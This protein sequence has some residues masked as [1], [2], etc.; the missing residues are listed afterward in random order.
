MRFYQAKK[1]DTARS[2]PCAGEAWGIF[3]PEALEASRAWLGE[4]LGKHYESFQAEDDAGN[5]VGEILWAWSE[6][7][8]GQ[9]RTEPKVAIISCVWVK[10]ASRRRGI[11]RGMLGALAEKLRDQGAKGILVLA[12]DYEGYMHR[13]HFQKSGFKILGDHDGT[14]VMFYPLSQE[15]VEYWFTEERVPRGPGDKLTVHMFMN[16]LCPIAPELFARTE[17]IAREFGDRIQVIKV[18][19]N[20]EALEKYGTA[21]GLYLNG[22]P[23]FVLPRDDD[24]IRDLLKEEIDLNPDIILD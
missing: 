10:S 24:A 17:R 16:L 5:I 3:G 8:L 14:F 13:S 1:E 21:R 12:T 20:P 2:Y 22:K 18:E 6:R 9:L 7:S 11:W 15:T 19:S 4:N 23:R